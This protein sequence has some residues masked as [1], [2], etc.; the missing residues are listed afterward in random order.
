MN[1]AVAAYRKGKSNVWFNVE[2]NVE[3]S[4]S[5]QGIITQNPRRKSD[6]I[7]SQQILSITLL[8]ENH[9]DNERFINEI[10]DESDNSNIEFV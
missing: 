10:G 1:R 6:V 9:Y 3:S 2:I 5:C 4:S 8:I 7:K